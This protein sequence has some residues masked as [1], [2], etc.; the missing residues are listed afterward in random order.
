[1]RPRTRISLAMTL[2]FGL[3]A[4]HA[5]AK[6]YVYLGAGGT[7]ID[8]SQRSDFG[9]GISGAFTTGGSLAFLLRVDHDQ[10]AGFHSNLA[11]AGIRS[12]GLKGNT[13]FVDI[14]VG[15]FV[16]S[17]ALYNGPSLMVGF[18]YRDPA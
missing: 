2:V 11:H 8:N 10:I 16:G 13:L 9:P 4:T 7:R 1:M 15:A 14:G 6:P 5:N 12:Q 18:G 3:I 17:N